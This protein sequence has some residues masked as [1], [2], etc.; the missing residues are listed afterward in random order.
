[1]F[2]TLCL[3]PVS[4]TPVINLYF[5][6]SLQIF[7]KLR[8]GPNWILRAGMKLIHRKN[9]KWKSSCQAPFKG[10]FFGIF[11]ILYSTVLHLL[12]T[13]S[14]DDGIEPRTLATLALAV[15]RYKTGFNANGGNFMRYVTRSL[16]SSVPIFFI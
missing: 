15:R 16:R 5:R 7:V 12:P 13:V 9:L 3:S 6:I 2:K 14:E 4:L 8:K 1:M 10:D 11:K